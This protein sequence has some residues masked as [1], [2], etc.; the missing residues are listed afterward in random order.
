MVANYTNAVV[1]NGAAQYHLLILMNYTA[2]VIKE[3]T[4]DFAGLSTLDLI[5]E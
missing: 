4:W 5:T 1:D 2:D 3:E